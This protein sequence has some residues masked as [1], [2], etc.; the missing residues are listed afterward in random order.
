MP[1]NLP[2][3]FPLPCLHAMALKPMKAMK[4]SK[5]MKTKKAINVGMK[6]M[7]ATKTMKAKA[8]KA[9]AVSKIARG[10]FAKSAVLS[11]RKEKTSGGLR[12]GDLTKNGHGKVVSRKMS[13]RGKRAWAGSKLKVWNDAVKK[14]RKVLGLKGFVAVGGKTVA[15]QALHAKAKALM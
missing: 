9:K 8:R 4:A 5:T 15:G 12:R 2:P 11:G 1:T 3:R 6:A 14:A 10:M 7:K 13:A